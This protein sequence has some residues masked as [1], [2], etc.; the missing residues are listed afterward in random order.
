MGHLAW[1]GDTSGNVGR[2]PTPP[3]R[4]KR[5]S[6]G[7]ERLRAGAAD[8]QRD[9]GNSA[10]GGGGAA[11]LR[12]GGDAGEAWW[13]SVCERYNNDGVGLAASPIV[14][15]RRAA[16]TGASATIGGPASDRCRDAA[17]PVLGRRAR[18]AGGNEFSN[19]NCRIGDVAVD[20]VVGG[21][22]AASTP[23]APVRSRP[24]SAT[25]SP[26]KA[27]RPSWGYPSPVPSSA[28]SPSQPSRAGSTPAKL[29][30]ARFDDMQVA[31]AFGSDSRRESRF[32][33]EYGRGSIPCHIDHGTC[34]N[35]LS[36]EISVDEMA[37]RRGAL[38][39][40]CADGLR[41]TR[42]PHATVA[43]LAFADLVALQSEDRL[44]DEDLRR[45]MA[46][47]RLALMV[48][49][50]GNGGSRCAAG[51]T[52]A[53]VFERAL[54][55]LGQVV[56]AEGP[57]IVPHL[58]LVLPPIGKKMFLKAHREAVQESLRTLEH[59]GG[60]EAVKVM[61]RRGVLAGAS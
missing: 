44:E 4:D 23:Q 59:H 46:G 16:S 35:R 51:T 55:A 30:R 50:P 34:S 48:E 60:P 33:M 7:E 20:V 22:S 36:W 3:A 45:V 27:P 17:T 47:L 15:A 9:L 14:Q 12:R 40:L 26:E 6:G 43:R 18:A 49:V 53:S 57:R 19:T 8:E 42:H 38:L 52:A 31:P 1:G 32:A 13:E 2:T 25:R 54:I 56:A 28:P 29:S 10:H 37:M 5:E 58:H 39:A 21:Y 61:R 41:E 24:K 11:A